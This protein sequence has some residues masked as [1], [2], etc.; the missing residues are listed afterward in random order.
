MKRAIVCFWAVL[1]SG[2]VG[3]SSGGKANF[4]QESFNFAGD[5][6]KYA[7]YT[8]ANYDPQKKYSAVLFLH[9]LFE[10]GQ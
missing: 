2:L 1:M 10:S 6:R 9:G 5:T 4:K 7:I 3:C 8:P